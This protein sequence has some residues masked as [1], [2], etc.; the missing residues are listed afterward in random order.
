M[1]RRLR[2]LALLLAFTLLFSGPG[3]A[4]AQEEEYH[5]TLEQAIELALENNYQVRLNE[6]NVEKAKLNLEQVKY[7]AKKIDK[8]FVRTYDVA[9]AK[10]VLPMSA[11]LQLVVAEAQARLSDDILKLNVEKNYYDLLKAQAA[12]KN[13]EKA[14][15]RAKEQLRIARAGFEAGA[16]AQSEVIGA[17]VLVATKEAQ[18]LTAQNQYEKARVALAESLGLPLDSKIVPVSQFA[19]EPLEVDLAQEI[20]KAKENDLELIAARGSIPIAEETFKQ[21]K[22]FY[23]PNVFMYR[24]AEYQLEEAKVKAKQRESALELN[25]RQAYLDLK[26]AEQAYRT[27]EKSL[28][29]AQE[30]Y[31][32]AKV[33]FEAGAATR[34]EVDQAAGALE[35]QEEKLMEMLYT[36]NLAAAQFR[37]GLFLNTSGAANVGTGASLSTAG[38]AAP[39]SAAMSMGDGGEM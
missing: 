21:A 10:Y 8:Q 33:R 7:R 27:L 36:Y 23:T 2:C 9:L 16:M 32:V 22:Y 30:T 39:S 35:E 26:S 29:S 28:A 1:M 14:L 15:E 12:L 24:E 17:E 11:E 18:V 20:E 3:A 38:A 19:F 31:R 37:Y 25:V 34:L 4:L 6:L 5:L 13:A